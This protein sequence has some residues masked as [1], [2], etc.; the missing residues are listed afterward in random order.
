MPKILHRAPRWLDYNTPGYNFFQDKTISKS[1][2]TE[3]PEAPS[4]KIAHRENEVFFAV[5]KELRWTNIDTLKEAVKGDQPPY[6]VLITPVP[7]DRA[8]QQI[9]ISPEGS[10]IAVL[11]SHTCHV[12]I[13]PPPESLDFS[14]QQKL[15]LKYFQV[16]ETAHVVETSPLVSAIWHPLSPSGNGLVTVTKD[17]CV[18]L[19][20]LDQENRITFSQPTV[21]VD[22]K[23]LA[24]ATSARDDLGASTYGTNKGFSADDVDMLVAGACFGGQ[25]LE[26]EDG[27]SSMTLWVAMTEGD[28]YALCPFLPTEFWAPSTLLPSLTT[29]VVAKAGF[30]DNDRDAT[31]HELRTSRQQQAWL[32]ELDEQDPIS[33]PGR[34]E[35]DVYSRPKKLS[36]I[37]KLQGPFQLS[38]E[39]LDGEI[40]DIHVVAP[41]VNQEDLFEDEDFEDL[42]VD[43]GLSIAVVCLATSTNQVH[44]C[45]NVE[46]VE[47]EWLPAKRPR[48]FQLDEDTEHNLLLFETIDLA[49]EGS[50]KTYPTFTTSPA[51]RY[52]IF[53]TQPSGIYSLSF[54]PW[55]GMLEDE[56]A[57]SEGSQGIGFRI[58]IILKSLST[59]VEDISGNINEPLQQANAAIVILDDTDAEYIVLTSDSTRP[60]ATV[61]DKPAI[62]SHPFEPDDQFQSNPLVTPESRTPYIPSDVFFKKSLLGPQIDEW[63]R[64]SMSGA[65]RGNIKGAVN[66]SPYT[67]QKIT[68]AH[69]IISEETHDLNTAAADLFRRIER[70]ISEMKAQIDRVRD[71]S[72]RVNSVTGEDEFPQSQRPGDPELVRG[73]RNKIQKRVEQQREKTKEIQD[74]VERLRKKMRSI[75][76]KEMSLKE[77][78]FAEEVER[79]QQTVLGKQQ[80]NPTGPAGIL[81][82]E[83]SNLTTRTEEEEDD[84]NSVVDRFEEVT[85]VVKQLKAQAEQ[86]QKKAEEATAE[87]ESRPTSRASAAAQGPDYRQRKMDHVWELIERET[88]LVNAVSARLEGL[89]METR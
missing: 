29:S 57:P 42:A 50:T 51:D 55:I 85:R 79:I 41:K 30:L 26:E 72:N 48:G 61:L 34:Y 6:K 46:G 13:L 5:G 76:G 2:A 52:E 54:K 65:D 86:I 80:S 49:Q 69:Q 31:E 84:H 1:K 81:H 60:V 45:L 88:A 18:R 62:A 21:A 16:G 75:G 35:F 83:N 66:F 23:K 24:N 3:T 38:P 39:P 64:A 7:S 71:L 15:K 78:Q 67:L 59:S 43:E 68:A 12:C 70:M 53:T 74:R 47:A 33:V 89:Q 20:E 87:A 40:T 27:W 77:R 19:W 11:T 63:R 8:I 22:L 82:M 37:A 25:G 44:V 10:F 36:S 32:Q 9:S 17:A 73:G 28:V 14:D 4:R 58:D 56:L